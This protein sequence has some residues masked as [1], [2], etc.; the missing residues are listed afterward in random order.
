ML[1][2][3]TAKPDSAINTLRTPPGAT[4]NRLIMDSKLANE[5]R[6]A[7]IESAKRLTREER[8]RTF[9]RHSKL[10]TDL[11]EASRRARAKSRSGG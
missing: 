4:Y 3:A 6:K 7:L 1:G 9:V 5:S 10:V 2:F 8:L 11:A